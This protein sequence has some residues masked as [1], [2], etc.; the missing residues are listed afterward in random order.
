MLVNK[1]GMFCMP[2]HANKRHPG[3]PSHL[4]GQHVACFEHVQLLTHAEQQDNKTFYSSLL[5]YIL[6]LRWFVSGPCVFT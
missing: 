4:S 3:A 2:D 5:I 1:V 6:S